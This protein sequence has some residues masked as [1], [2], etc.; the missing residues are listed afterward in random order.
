MGGKVLKHNALMMAKCNEESWSGRKA[1]ELHET[2]V[3][4]ERTKP[5]QARR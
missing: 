2:Q 5:W 3:M 1:M 4:S